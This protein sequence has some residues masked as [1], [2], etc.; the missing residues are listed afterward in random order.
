MNPDF[1]LVIC[2]PLAQQEKYDPD[3]LVKTAR[4]IG[5]RAV[6][7]SPQLKAACQKYTIALIPA[8][9]GESLSSQQVIDRMVRNRQQGK[10]TFISVNLKENGDL[11]EQSQTLCRTI[12]QWMHLFGH[13][14]NEGAISQLRVDH[15]FVLTN[16]HANYQKYV[17]LKEPLPAR[18]K[19][20]GLKKEPNRVEWIANRQD[21]AFHFENG[22]LTITLTKPAVSAPW[23]VLRIQ[24]HRPEDDLK[25]T[26][27]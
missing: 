26:K 3:F 7:G 15:G 23:Q 10:A 17:F 11:T 18:I 4:N 13:A 14:F 5:A 2:F 6:S 25:S 12:N 16:R 24:A 1:A 20:R 9:K 22:L 21:L 19:L 27:F 8:H